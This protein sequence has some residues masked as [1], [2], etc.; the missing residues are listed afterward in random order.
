MANL[1]TRRPAGAGAKIMRR[2]ERKKTD[3]LNYSFV[4]MS[5]VSRDV[6]ENIQAAFSKRAIVLH[7]RICQLTLCMLFFLF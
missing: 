3:D 7:A 5:S 2:T 4:L 6:V 1:A